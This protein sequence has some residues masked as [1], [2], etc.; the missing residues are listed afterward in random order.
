MSMNS[1]ERHCGLL[2][3]GLLAELLGLTDKPEV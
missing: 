3:A 2:V 1:R